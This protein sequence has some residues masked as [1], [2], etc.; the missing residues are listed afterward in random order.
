MKMK[1]VHSAKV[2]EPAPSTWTNAKLYGNQLFISGMT[3]HDGNGNVEGDGSI[4]DQARRTFQKIKDLI[5][6]EGGRMND[7]IQ[8]TI[9][10]TD[11]TQRKEVWRARQEFF[12]GDFPCSTLVEVSALA[13]PPIHVEI[14]AQAF[15]GAAED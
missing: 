5:E 15:I 4:Y 14:N 10:L 3:A 2:R 12:S 13:A 11:I 7:I 8:M 9:F 1:S 6:A